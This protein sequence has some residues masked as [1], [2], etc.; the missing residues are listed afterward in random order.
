[1][2]FLKLLFLFGFLVFFSFYSY[3]F[4]KNETDS[5]LVLSG[6]NIIDGNGFPAKYNMDIV[7]KNNIIVDIF[8]HNSKKYPEN[9]KILYLENQYVIPGLIDSHIHLIYNKS[10]KSLNYALRYGITSIRDM[11]G[12][13]E[14]LKELQTAI[15]NNEIKAPDIYFSAVFCGKESATDKLKKVT[16]DCYKFGEAPWLR[17]VDSTSNI[18][19]F[20]KEAKECGATGIKITSGLNAETISKISDEAHKLGLQVW[21]HAFVGPASAE[22]ISKINVE[23]VSHAAT[24]ILPENFNFATHK[25]FEIDTNFIKSGKLDEI[26]ENYKNNK[27]FIDATLSVQDIVWVQ[28]AAAYGFNIEVKKNIVFEILKLAYKKGVSITTGTDVALPLNFNEKPKL[29]LEMEYLVNKVGMP[30]I[31]VIKCATLNGAKV[32]GIDNT[33]GTVEIGKIANLVVLFKNP[34]ENI[35]NISEINIVIKNGQIM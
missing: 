34:E 6:V 13:A 23:S 2:K 3:S 15:L 8:E 29:F 19:Q 7:I 9:S 24:I 30:P 33:H 26:L 35:K 20:V 10:E 25:S 16:P 11:G 28:Q 4:K 1:M 21:V 18:R 32:L 27:T 12:D 22:E 14:Y 31:D 17:F 5:F